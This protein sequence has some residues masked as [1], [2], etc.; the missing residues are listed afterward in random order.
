[1]YMEFIY[2]LYLSRQMQMI[3]TYANMRKFINTN[4]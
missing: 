4:K 1:M 3:E 2:S